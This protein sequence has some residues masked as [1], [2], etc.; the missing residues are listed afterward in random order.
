MPLNSCGSLL[1]PLHGLK[2][3][4]ASSALGIRLLCISEWLWGKFWEAG[5][6]GRGVTHLIEVKLSRAC[7]T[8]EEGL[9][10]DTVGGG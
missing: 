4:S 3:F 6:D 5:E 2:G 10:E 7:E 8:A 1:F 9:Q